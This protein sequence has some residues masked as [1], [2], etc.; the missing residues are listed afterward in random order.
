MALIRFIVVGLIVLTVIYFSI[1]IYSRSVRREKLEKAWDAD[2]PSGDASDREAFIES[3]MQDYESGF[4]KRLILLVYVI[5][6]VAVGIILYVT[7]AN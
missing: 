2:H 7:N 4:R 6:I 1:S 3:G 5:P